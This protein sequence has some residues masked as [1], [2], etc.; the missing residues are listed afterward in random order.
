M[1]YLKGIIDRYCLSQFLKLALEAFREKNF[2][3]AIE[4]LEMIRQHDAAADRRCSDV[5]LFYLVEAM[6]SQAQLHQKGGN[7]SGAVAAYR[8]ALKLAPK[9]ADIHLALGKLYA[10]R[11]QAKPALRH[12][13]RAVALNPNF[14]E[15]HLNIAHLRAEGGDLGGAI[16]NF[17]S[18]AKR[19]SYFRQDAYDRAVVA[20]ARGKPREAVRL[21]SLAFSTAPDRCESLC[22]MGRDAMRS[23]QV[24]DAL[25]LFRQA[26][27]IRPKYADIHNLMGVCHSHR[28]EMGKSVKHL[29]KAVSLAPNFTRAWLNLAYA[30]EQRGDARA[31]LAAYRRVLKLDPKNAIASAA[32]RRLQAGGRRGGMTA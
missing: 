15:A 14:I 18:L 10:G 3:Q 31:S 27:R 30:H 17:R 28:G 22:A 9:Y 24:G 13:G 20:A 11:H 1:P 25:N 12:L 16:R 21:F 23:G 2:H 6:M 32:A 26:L 4:S 19:T 29:L 5:V 7:Y 8:R